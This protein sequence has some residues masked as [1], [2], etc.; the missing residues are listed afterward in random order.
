MTLKPEEEVHRSLGSHR[1]KAGSQGQTLAGQSPLTH[2]ALLLCC[3]YEH[4][5]K[6][7]GGGELSFRL[8]QGLDRISQQFQDFGSH[9][10]DKWGNTVIY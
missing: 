1:F 5:V 8:S 10:M 2:I 6:E 3:W 4:V 7:I 9:S